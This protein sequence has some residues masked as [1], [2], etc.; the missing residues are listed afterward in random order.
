MLGRLIKHEFRATGRRMPP[1]L[2][3]LA[4]LGLLA[5]LSIRILDSGFGGS[6][7]RVLLTLF[8]IAFFVG[9]IAAW[10]MALVLMII[11][12]YRNLLKD[13]G[14]LMFTLPTDA[15]AL[16]WSKLIVSTVWFLAT[17]LTIFLLMLL[18]GVNLAHMSGANFD[19]VFR[20]MGE[21]LELLRS[22]GVTN[23]SLILLGVEFVVAMVLSSLATCLHFYAAMGLGQMSAEHKVLWSVLAFVGLSFAFRFLGTAVFAGLAGTESMD[24]V[25][26]S[27][28]ELAQSAPGVVRVIHSGIG[29]VMLLELLQGA[30]LYLITA[31][32][33]KKKLNLA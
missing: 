32:T 4:L 10:I 14:Y 31:L 13:E 26:R 29:G 9:M 25:I 3:V 27:M 33:L 11:R 18:T 15:H 19:E 17:A 23:G 8:I 16:I 24:L 28:E 5:N 12:F 1:A 7:L 20:G 2:G 21:G 30:V 22:L 6:L